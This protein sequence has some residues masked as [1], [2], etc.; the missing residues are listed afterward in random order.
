MEPILIQ[1]IETTNPVGRVRN[2]S[3]ISISAL[4]TKDTLLELLTLLDTNPGVERQDLYSDMARRLSQIAGKEPEWSWRYVQSVASGTVEPG[5]KFA[6]AVEL[7]AVTFDG[8]PV[9]LAGI[10]PVTV[11]AQA[12]TV[13]NGALVM[14]PSR[15]CADPVCV[16]EFVP[17]VPWRRYC[18]VC[19]PSK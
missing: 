17:N 12:G 7:L 10:S 14:S 8:I 13:T 1:T 2:V 16:N 15:K 19:K 3:E 11:Y 6:K 18:P 5:G 4:S 9:R